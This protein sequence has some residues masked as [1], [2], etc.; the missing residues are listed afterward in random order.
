MGQPGG[1]FA[2]VDVVP[3]QIR[4]GHRDLFSRAELL[5]IA[6]PLE[7]RRIR[8]RDVTLGKSRPVQRIRHPDGARPVAELREQGVTVLLVEQNASRAIELADRSYVFVKGEVVAAGS[9]EDFLAR[10][11]LASLYLGV[12]QAR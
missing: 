12:E 1:R 2:P 8:L 7:Q 5:R 6:Q 4:L 10:D 11:D 3:G 9:R